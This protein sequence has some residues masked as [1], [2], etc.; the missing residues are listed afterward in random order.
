MILMSFSLIVTTR[1]YVGNPID[2]IHTKDIPEDVLNTFCWIH[3]TYTMKHLFDKKVGVEVAYPGVGTSQLEKLANGGRA[4]PKIYRY[5]QWVCFL[6][7]FQVKKTIYLYKESVSIWNSKKLIWSLALQTSRHCV[8]NQRH[9]R[10]IIVYFMFTIKAQK[11]A[12]KIENI[13]WANYVLF[14]PRLQHSHDV[15]LGTWRFCARFIEISN[16][17]PKRLLR[18]FCLTQHTTLRIMWIVNFI[19]VIIQNLSQKSKSA[20][21]AKW[22][23]PIL[24][25]HCVGVI[26]LKTAIEREREWVWE[27]ERDYYGCERMSVR[28]I[29]KC[30]C[31]CVRVYSHNMI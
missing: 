12:N 6:L 7:F 5:Y 3:S 17:I 13:A 14:L 20:E 18:V 2:C 4:E 30:V 16:R 26:A 11:C 8:Y 22:T 28:E 9:D 31:V 19:D 23:L 29:T 24:Q 21:S 10:I 27:R 25:R 15:W 1:Q